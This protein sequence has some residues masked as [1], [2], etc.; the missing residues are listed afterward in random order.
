MVKKVFTLLFGVAL[1]LSLSKPLVAQGASK[2]GSKEAQETTGK[3]SA[4]EARWEGEVS[5]LNRDAHTLT[6]RKRGETM[7]KTIHYGTS[8]RFVSQEHGSKEVKDITPNDIK[9]G[10]RVICV[11]HYD[12]KKEFA[13]TLVSKRLTKVK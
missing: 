6:V 2:E 7:D 13:A 1:A 9:E 12:N 11:G 3:A 10:D 5:R 8:T 4:K